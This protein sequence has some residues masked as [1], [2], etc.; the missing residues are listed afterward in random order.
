[1]LKEIYKRIATLKSKVR[2]ESFL[3]VINAIPLPTTT[4]TVLYRTEPE[5]GLDVDKERICNHMPQPAFFG[6]TPLAT[7]LLGAL[8]HFV[9]RNNLLRTSNTYTIKNVETDFNTSY[10]VLK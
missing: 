5:L 9:M 4:I 6:A 8:T 1:M 7:K 2:Q 10:T 3:K